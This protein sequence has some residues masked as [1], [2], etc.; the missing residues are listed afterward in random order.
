M[1]PIV[2]VINKKE[3]FLI[4]ILNNKHI[5]LVFVRE[6]AQIVNIVIMLSEKAEKTKNIYKRMS[7]FLSLGVAEP[8]KV[9][10]FM[11]ARKIICL[12]F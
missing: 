9:S 6:Y 7:F 12:K 3:M 4:D 8:G 5:R 11:A 2:A 1:K 10:K